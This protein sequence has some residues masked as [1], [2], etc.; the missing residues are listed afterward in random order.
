MKNN[1]KIYDLN[2]LDINI[3]NKALDY[4]STQASDI[5]YENNKEIFKNDD[6]IEESLEKLDLNEIDNNKNKGLIYL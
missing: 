2:I 6:L 4:Q 1:N 3:G 5:F